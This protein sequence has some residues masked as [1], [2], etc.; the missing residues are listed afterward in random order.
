M[1]VSAPGCKAE[2]RG[3]DFHPGQNICSQKYLFRIWLYLT[4]HSK[5]Q[6]TFISC[7]VTIVQALRSLESDSHV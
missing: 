5:Y 4:M 7:L 3:F 2:G 1:V 6:S